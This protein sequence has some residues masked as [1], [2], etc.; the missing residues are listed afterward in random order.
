MKQRLNKSSILEELE[1]SR[2]EQLQ[3]ENKKILLIKERIRREQIAIQN[4]DNE[5]RQIQEQLHKQIMSSKKHLCQ[6]INFSSIL[7]HQ[8]QYDGN[9]IV[10][11]M[12]RQ[13]KKKSVPQIEFQKS[14]TYIKLLHEQQEEQLKLIAK[15]QQ[16]KARKQVQS[17]YSEIVKEIY[18]RP[19][20]KTFHEDP[21]DAFI[22]NSKSKPISLHEQSNKT[23]SEVSQLQQIDKYLIKKLEKILQV[24]EKLEEKKQPEIKIKV[25]HQ[26]VQ[27]LSPIPQPQCKK[28]DQAE[29]I[30]IHKKVQEIQ[31]AQW[32]NIFDDSLISSQDRVQKTLD[33][34]KLLNN[35]ALKLEEETNTKI[36]VEKEEK[37]NNLLINQIQARLALLDNFN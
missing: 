16:I 15:R 36:N 6:P 29:G 8:Q 32:R 27:K 14:N 22:F 30:H 7:L 37:L 24:E 31:P 26:Q 28:K 5:L 3:E 18:S 13:N 34:I 35:E 9:K 33:Q 2:K 11:E 25:R 19:I 21:S 4:K 23:S 20:I 10:R 17:K 12:E 1:N